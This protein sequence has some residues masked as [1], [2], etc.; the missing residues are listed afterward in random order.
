MVE[1]TYS[2]KGVEDHKKFCQALIAEI[3]TGSDLSRDFMIRLIAF[4]DA[5]K[6]LSGPHITIFDFCKC[7]KNRKDYSEDG[8]S[9]LILLCGMVPENSSAQG[10]IDPLLIPARDILIIF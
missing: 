6:E 1:W 10:I 5:N 4:L 3:S 9:L 7:V 8:W 2:A